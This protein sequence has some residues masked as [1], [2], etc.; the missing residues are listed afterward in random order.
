MI[1]ITSNNYINI[2]NNFNREIIFSNE[3]ILG[4]GVAGVVVVEV[5]VVIVVVAV[6][7]E[8]M[9]TMTENCDLAK[10]LKYQL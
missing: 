5:V 9:K 8:N 3:T 6:N 1:D 10:R 7:R 2:K 4:K